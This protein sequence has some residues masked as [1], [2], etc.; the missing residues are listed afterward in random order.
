MGA[1]TYDTMMVYEAADSL[2]MTLD[3]DPKKGVRGSEIKTLM[4]LGGTFLK[5]NQRVVS[6]VAFTD[7]HVFLVR[8]LGNLGAI[9][10]VNRSLKKARAT[11][12]L[13]NIVKTPQLE[14]LF[15][16]MRPKDAAQAYALVKS[17]AVET[18][19]KAETYVWRR[20]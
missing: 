3:L 10:T 8:F 1:V 17:G 9:L 4:D 12:T 15:E 16:K 13:L 20:V 5:A 19:E 7:T 18:Y 6:S 2:G 11:M 14:D